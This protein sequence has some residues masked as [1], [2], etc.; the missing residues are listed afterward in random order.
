MMSALA[1]ITMVLTL[2]EHNPLSEDSVYIQND[3]FISIIFKL[4]GLRNDLQGN[5]IWEKAK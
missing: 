1:G 2:Y 4:T 3:V 5:I